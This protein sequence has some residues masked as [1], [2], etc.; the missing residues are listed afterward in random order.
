[1]HAIIMYIKFNG[2]IIM[3]ISKKLFHFFLAILS[4]IIVS[5]NLSAAF[6]YNGVSPYDYKVNPNFNKNR[7]LPTQAMRNKY[8]EWWAEYYHPRTYK[9]ITYTRGGNIFPD[10]AELMVKLGPKWTGDNSG[11]YTMS[12][13]FYT[14][15]YSMIDFARTTGDPKVLDEMVYFSNIMRTHF[16]DWDGRGYKFARFY[17]HQNKQAIKQHNAN[18]KVILDENL[19]FGMMTMYAWVFHQNR[20]LSPEYAEHADWWFTYYDEVHVPKWLA[21]TTGEGRFGG[22]IYT[23]PASL[24]LENATKR[25]GPGTANPLQPQWSPFRP[26]GIKL[27]RDTLGWHTPEFPIMYPTRNY[28][29]PLANSIVGYWLLGKYFE[30]VGR[31]PKG[32]WGALE[33][34]AR[35]NEYIIEAYTR[36]RYW[37]RG[38]GDGTGAPQKDGS[39]TYWMQ[40]D[41]SKG[42]MRIGSYGRVTDPVLHFL[43]YNRFPMLKDHEDM[44][45]YA[46][47]Y[48]N[49]DYPDTESVY[50]DINDIINGKT[51]TMYRFSNGKGNKQQGS[52][53]KDSWQ[54]RSVGYFAEF[55]ETGK[56]AELLDFGVKG[57]GKPNAHLIGQ[58]S[59]WQS[60]VR[61]SVTKNRVEMGYLS[62]QLSLML[63]KHVGKVSFTPTVT[64]KSV[65]VTQPEVSSN[66]VVTAT[67]VVET[68]QSTNVKSDGLKPVVIDVARSS[69][70]SKDGVLTLHFDTLN[71]EFHL[72]RIKAGTKSYRSQNK[73]VS[74]TNVY[75][76]KVM[77]GSDASFKSPYVIKG[78]P[79]NGKNIYVTIEVR[80]DGEKEF[81][82]FLVKAPKS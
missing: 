4:L 61:P 17:A 51:I 58:G 62:A 64:T 30:D 8:D 72:V 27:G 60:A 16:Q 47:M 2:A 39:R 66:P 19:M 29:H 56:I 12:R 38:T 48:Y 9:G 33:K 52:G 36:M 54:V 55:D 23:P 14:F 78:I 22:K 80:K 6:A 67:P 57:A 15:A 18:D 74:S 50:G 24:G 69:S 82:T 41:N 32:T 49:P 63:A 7:D 1:M 31:S 20:D 5:S 70:I 59:T 26:P 81:T 43:H 37:N 42:G 68:Q 44:V 79:T 73:R 77:K 34:R 40:T 13:A 75:D 76:S 10:P 3:F 65:E 71:Q 53:G 46:K 21:R 28:G 11:I 25:F 45:P 35:A